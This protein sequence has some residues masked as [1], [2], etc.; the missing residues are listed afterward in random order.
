M[1]GRSERS[2]Q[3]GRNT[4]ALSSLSA[5]EIGAVAHDF[6]LGCWIANLSGRPWR[7]NHLSGAGAA[8]CLSSEPEYGVR[9]LP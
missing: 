3:I 6:P 5:C 1:V 2:A 7:V 4:L 8:G 9:I